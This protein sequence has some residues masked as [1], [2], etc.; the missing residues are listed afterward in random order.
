MEKQLTVRVLDGYQWCVCCLKFDDR[1]IITGSL[2]K[3]TMWDKNSGKPIGY[4]VLFLKFLKHMANLF[5]F[6]IG[7]LRGTLIG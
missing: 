1:I 3:I 2:N 4:G 5:E 6:I 7:N